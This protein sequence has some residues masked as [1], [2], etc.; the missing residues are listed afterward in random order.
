MNPQ[1]FRLGHSAYVD[2][3]L[4]LEQ[5]LTQA[6]ADGPLT[7][8]PDHEGLGFIYVTSP[9]A[10]HL[11]AIV[12]AARARTGIMSWAGGV[13]HGVMAGEQEY[14]DHAALVLMLATL[15][16]GSFRVF[17]GKD[18]ISRRAA[19]ASSLASGVLVHADPAQTDLA[20]MLTDITRRFGQASVFGGVVS[21]DLEQPPQFANS[22]VHGGVSG[23]VFDQRVGI[24]SRMSQGCAPL[25]TEHRVTGCAGQYLRT[26]DG[27]P[28]LDVM[29][30]DLGV[31]EQ[32]RRS[33]DGDALLRALPAGRLRNGLLVGLAAD[34]KPK[35]GAGFSARRIGLSDYRVRNIIGIDPE[36]RIVA[37]ADDLSEGDK[38]VFCTRDQ[39]SARN[40]L[41]RICTE[42]R[43]ELESEGLQ[44]C[45]ALYYS[46]VARGQNLFGQSGA[47]LSIIRHNLGD[48]PVA[49]FFAN[50]EISGANLYA[51]TGVLTLFTGPAA[52]PPA[53]S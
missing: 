10:I 3:R 4:A 2:W 26:L 24:Q 52:T 39:T 38:A 7:T 15:P 45:G 34:A 19:S 20:E 37:I 9:L 42:L 11:P 8:D 31:D 41:I 29:L 47:E 44:V 21:G 50:G 40:D 13:G 46:C 33:R 5:S 14:Q 6:L 36:N 30:R 43:E 18:P 22:L 23:V 32:A 51:Y 17:S 48:I 35:A 27:E 1:R 53:P 16:A 28:A 12:D 25:G 49:G